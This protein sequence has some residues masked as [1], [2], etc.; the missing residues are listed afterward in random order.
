VQHKG[1]DAMH[2]ITFSKEYPGYSEIPN[3]SRYVISDNGDVIRKNDG[4]KLRGS[5]NPAGYHN[6]RL[7][8]D[9]G[10]VHTWGRHRLV[11]Y[12]FEYRADYKD[13]EVN[14][15]K[16]NKADNRNSELEWVTPKQNTHHAGLTGLS[17]K[18]IPI[19]IRFIDTGRVHHFD[20]TIACSEFLTSMGI[21]ITKWQVRYRVNNTDTSVFPERVQY[22]RLTNVNRTEPW[23]EIEKTDDLERQLS[24]FGRNI[25]VL[26]W[27]VISNLTMRFN[28]IVEAEYWTGIHGSSLVNW[29]K[30]NKTLKLR[31]GYFVVKREDD[32]RP[33]PVFEDIWLAYD[34]LYGPKHVVTIEEKTGKV[35]LFRSS[36]ECCKEMGIGKTTLSYRIKKSKGM[37]S[38]PDGYRYAYYIDVHNTVLPDGN[39]GVVSSLIAGTS[40]KAPPPQCYSKES[41]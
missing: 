33:W 23:K 15:K 17:N 28:S 24:K 36:K 21:P 19:S 25:P 7:T 14:H 38:Y 31:P 37:Y 20:S 10:K 13:L 34:E 2:E 35:R 41:V 30:D 18:C 4:V 12:V 8:D 32:V 11:K 40:R 5:V 6:V 16:G 39:V 27:N 3:Y 9:S 1:V 29:I 26:V 22:R